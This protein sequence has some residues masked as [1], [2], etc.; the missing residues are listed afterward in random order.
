M[1]SWKTETRK[2]SDLKG[3]D[4]NPRKISEKAYERLKKSIQDRGFHDVLKIDENNVVL[5]G[6]QRLKALVELGYDEVECKVCEQ[7]LTEKEKREVA[8]ESNVQDGEFDLEMLQLEFE[9]ELK[10]LGFDDLL[11]GT[12][13][14][15]NDWNYNYKGLEQTGDG[16]V[17]TLGFA[18]HSMWYNIPRDYGDIKNKLVALPERKNKNPHQDKY[19]RTNPESIRRIVK[20]YMREGDMFLEN[21]C[22]WSTFG[23][24]AKSMGFSGVGIDIWDVA[25]KY[26][27]KQIQ[28]IGGGGRVEILKMD[29]MA[30]K[31]EDNKFDYIYC[32]PPFMDAELY[33][34]AENDI[35][36][37]DRGEFE[38]KFQ[39]LM[40]EN[41]RVVRQDGLCTITISDQR[42]GGRLVP[43]QK[44]VIDCGI[45]AGFVLHDF[46]IVE[47]LGVAN[48]YRKKAFNR[49]YSPKNHEYVITFKK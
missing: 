41:Y 34:G 45:R 9:D 30:T 13:D 35:A 11:L 29:G 16:L 36:C 23:A 42:R 8:I 31:F 46:V 40:N 7:I 12:G 3:W 6:N 25:I 24:I 4:K 20:M 28:T 21:C 2:I 33:S 37:S 47:Q 26:S 18:P 48:M 5:S 22:G 10:E 19:S 43:N 39:R 17:D 44:L 27:T 49:K 14:S 15:A 32:N 1:I 38:S